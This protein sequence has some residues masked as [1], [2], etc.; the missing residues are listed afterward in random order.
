MPM[1]PPSLSPSH[2]ANPT[3]SPVEEHG[4]KWSDLWKQDFIPWDQAKP[5][6]ALE[7]LFSE[8]GSTLLG[9]GKGKTALVPGCGKGY[10]VALFA[11]YGVD[12]TGLEISET[13]VGKAREWHEQK[14]REE[15][16][17]DWAEMR[18]VLGDFYENDWTPEGGFDFVYDYTVSDP[19][20]YTCGS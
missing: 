14:A 13:A 3:R 10:D 18:F 19:G 9:L 20:N 17:K 15:N 12:A 8:R 6:P 11:S 2:P 1:I 7:D 5:S 16:R 4:T